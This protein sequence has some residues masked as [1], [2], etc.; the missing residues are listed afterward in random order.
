[1]IASVIVL[2]LV[3]CVFA[4]VTA[5]DITDEEYYNLP[6]LFHLDRYD[7]CLSQADGLYCL[8][9]F[10]L[11]SDEENPTFQLMQ[12]YSSDSNHYNHTQLHRGY[13]ISR[14][15]PQTASEKNTSYRFEL[16][17]Q[18]WADTHSLHS[19]LYHLQYCHTHEDISEANTLQPDTLQLV[20]AAVVGLILLMNVVGTVYDLMV[21]D[22]SKKSKALSAWS[23]ASN[24]RR[25]LSNRVAA[26]PARAALLPLEGARV[27]MLVLVIVVHTGFIYYTLYPYSP[28]AAE[29]L[30]QHPLVAVLKSGTAMVQCFVVLT[31]FLFGYNILL[32][33]KSEAIT[34]K[35]LPKCIFYRLIR[36]S[37]VHLLVVWFAGTWWVY[38]GSGPV[39]GAVT[40]ESAAC[41]HRLW[42][43]ALYAHNLL[44]AD[45][46]CLLPTWFLAMD[47]QL[48]LVAVVLTIVLIR[49]GRDSV[50]ILGVLFLAS[51]LLNAVLIYIFE[52]KSM[53]YIMNPQNTHTRFVDVPSFHQFYMSPW[54]SLPSSILGLLVA[55]I[56]FEQQNQGFKAIKCKWLVWSYKLSIPMM[57]GLA[58]LG[59]Y[60]DHYTSP[61]VI[62][63]YTA[64][65]RPVFVL[66][67]A[68]FLLGLFNDLD[69]VYSA[70]FSWGGWRSLGRVSLSV[71]TI[72]WCVGMMLVAARQHT[73]T[74][75]IPQL[76]VDAIATVV[77]TYLISVPVTVLVE[78][79]VHRFFAALV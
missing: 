30:M 79:P 64:L 22:E 27:V 35:M 11:T 62:L 13:C 9:T 43:H 48:Y 46:F 77:I 29:Q 24:W 2:C 37:P 34:F 58:S 38:S 76:L 31:S 55:N 3:G 65:E 23:A 44:P 21:K 68:I 45:Y 70:V 78:M 72:H 57:V 63:V 59:T 39:W 18:K 26:D 28:R 4:I 66:V 75:S 32:Y 73:I 50:R 10:H 36:I 19:Q 8:G 33:S 47:M 14:R 51:C 52:W 20:F 16:C 56:Y 25:L 61:I 1:M 53:L 17:V 71:L 67:F 41:R 69:D 12:E 6:P 54:G 60:L 7:A 40:A 5:R 42:V 74:F 49:L 15:C